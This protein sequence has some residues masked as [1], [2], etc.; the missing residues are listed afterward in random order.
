MAYLETSFLLWTLGFV[1]IA[2]LFS[3]WLARFSEGS[4]SQASFHGLFFACLALVGLITMV[5]VAFSF[6]Y[7][8]VSGA[9]LAVMILAAIWDV[10]PRP[11][12]HAEHL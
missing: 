6:R 3:A 2:G 11:Q 4:R 9:T 7:W 12:A 1:Q 5:A 10:S 8:L